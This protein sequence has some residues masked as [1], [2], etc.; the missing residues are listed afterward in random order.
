MADVLPGQLWRDNDGF[1]R[2]YGVVPVEGTTW[3]IL[4]RWRPD[5]DPKRPR[6]RRPFMFG[7][8]SMLRG[9]DGWE[10]VEDAPQVAPVDLEQFRPAVDA[11]FDAGRTRT[12][13]GFTLNAKHYQ[14]CELYGV[15]DAHKKAEPR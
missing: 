1:A 9:D 7:V 15:L 13:T 6:L 11:L 4:R 5:D 3:A 8:K 14:A 10:L 12:G 2:V